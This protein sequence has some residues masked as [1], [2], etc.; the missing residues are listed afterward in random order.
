MNNF[1]SGIRNWLGGRE[2]NTLACMRVSLAEVRSS[3]NEHV[4]GNTGRTGDGAPGAAHK[5]AVRTQHCK[6]LVDPQHSPCAF[7]PERISR[8]RESFEMSEK[9]GSGKWPDHVD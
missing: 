2:R 5:G 6:Q 1:F 8:R 9:S 7:I 4:N 3:F